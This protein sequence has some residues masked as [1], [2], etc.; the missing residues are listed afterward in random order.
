[1]LFY[2]FLL[3]DVDHVGSS[4]RK[5]TARSTRDAICSMI[6]PHHSAPNGLTNASTGILWMAQSQRSW[7]LILYVE[8]PWLSTMSSK[9]L[10]SLWSSPFLFVLGWNAFVVSR[11]WLSVTILGSQCTSKWIEM[12]CHPDSP[13]E[14]WTIHHFS[15]YSHMAWKER[16]FEP[17]NIIEP[18]PIS[19]PAMGSTHSPKNSA[20]LDGSWS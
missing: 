16:G 11:R 5:S 18:I 10:S 2:V 8:F 15:R 1:M 9:N 20:C 14:S 7:F 4:G 3:K 12:G 13:G 17:L 6:S 19:Q